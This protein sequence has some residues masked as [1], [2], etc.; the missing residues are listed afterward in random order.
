MLVWF[1]ATL[2]VRDPADVNPFHEYAALESSDP[3]ARSRVFIVNCADP[4]TGEGKVNR[5]R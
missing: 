2:L 3:E 4:V 5:I 1:D